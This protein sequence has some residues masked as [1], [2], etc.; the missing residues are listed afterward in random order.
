MNYMINTIMIKTFKTDK[1]DVLYFNDSVTVYS[2]DRDI[3]DGK[4][5][6]YTLWLSNHIEN[7]F[8]AYREKLYDSITDDAM[9]ILLNLLILNKKMVQYI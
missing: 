3:D 1:F 4:Q 2:Q 7:I 6:I 8:S 5:K 9:N